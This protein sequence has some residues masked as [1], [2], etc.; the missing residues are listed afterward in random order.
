M[1]E[2]IDDLE[3][4]KVNEKAMKRYRKHYGKEANRNTLYFEVPVI[5]VSGEAI[6]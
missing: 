6:I 5:S 1:N 2:A 3:W 4:N